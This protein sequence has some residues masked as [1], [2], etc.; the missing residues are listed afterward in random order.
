MGQIGTAIKKVLDDKHRVEGIDKDEEAEGKFDFLQICIPWSDEF[1]DIVK[2][3]QEKYLADE[4]VT[5]VHSTV[6]VGTC[7]DL[8]AVHSPVRGVHPDLEDGVRTFLKYFGGL[9][10]DLA[11]APF[12]ECGVETYIFPRSSDVEA[13][14]L[15]STT[16]YGW[17]IMFNKAVKQYCEENNLEF[18]LIYVHANAT[19]NQGYHKLGRGEVLR[20]VLKYMQGQIGGHCVI[21][22][23]DLLG[24]EIPEFILKQNDAI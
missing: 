8:G 14:K 15:W 23:C 19:Y 13:L 21:P 3:Y 6:K 12:E 1:V 24:G 4:G 17:N 10:S 16:Y 7:Q 18:N 9:E 11:A 22:N 20:P 5:V 2:A